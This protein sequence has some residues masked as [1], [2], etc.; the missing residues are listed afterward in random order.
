MF[1]HHHKPCFLPLEDTID[2]KLMNY[3]PMLGSCPEPMGK[4]KIYGS[5]ICNCQNSKRVFWPPSTV[6]KKQG[7]YA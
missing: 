7:T 4:A 1:L 5:L 3:E 6:L 2:C